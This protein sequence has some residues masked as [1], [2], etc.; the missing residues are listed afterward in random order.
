LLFGCSTFPH[1]ALPA[2]QLARESGGFY[3]V[4]Q[5]VNP[6]ADFWLVEVHCCRCF[7]SNAQVSHDSLLYFFGWRMASTVSW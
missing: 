6:A 3:G 1:V 4:S 2:R 5:T 7:F